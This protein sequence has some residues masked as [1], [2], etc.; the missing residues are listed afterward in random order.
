MIHLL[1]YALLFLFGC[2][3]SG[4]YA[5]A[6]KAWATVQDEAGTALQMAY[7]EGLQ[8]YTSTNAEGAF[9]L[10]A[11]AQDSLRIS[12]IGFEPLVVAASDC[13]GGILVLRFEVAGLAAAHVLGLKAETVLTRMLAHAEKNHAKGAGYHSG[14]YRLH[15][16]QGQQ[17][18]QLSE[19]LLAVDHDGDDVVSVLRTRAITDDA[20]LGELGFGMSPEVVLQMDKAM[21]PKTYYPFSKK[22]RKHHVYRLDDGLVNVDGRP[23]YKLFFDAVMYPRKGALKGHVLI[24]TASF[25][26]VYLSS[27]FSPRTQH[28]LK[29]SDGATRAALGLMGLNISQ[30]SDVLKVR[31]QRQEGGVW[32]LITAS[33]DSDLDVRYTREGTGFQP[34]FRM[35]YVVTGRERLELEEH[36]LGDKRMIEIMQADASPDFWADYTILFPDVD[37]ASVA[38]ELGRRNTSHNKQ[39]VLEQ[40]LQDWPEDTGARLD[41]TL[42][43]FER[44]GEFYGLALVAKGDSVIR[45]YASPG[46]DPDT[47]VAIGSIAKTYMAMTVLKLADEAFFELDNP[48]DIWLGDEVA[49]DSP[50]RQLTFRQLLTHRSGLDHGLDQPSVLFDFQSA[51][52]RWEQI[53]AVCGSPILPPDS[54]FRYSNGGY[55]LLGY[56]IES[57]SGRSLEFVVSGELLTELEAYC[58]TFPVFRQEDVKV[59]DIDVAYDPAWARGAGG[60]A[61]CTEDLLLWSNEVQNREIVPKHVWELATTA[62]SEYKDWSAFYGMGWM[63]DG[64]AFQTSAEHPIVYHP[65]TEWNAHS[66]LA[67]QPDTGYTVVLISLDGSFARYPMTDVLFTLLNGE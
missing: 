67:I 14:F 25:A 8:N 28:L 22:G 46:L 26:L 56:V 62:V 53:E 65:G 32:R 61:A 12:H 20:K 49:E 31:Y 37:F 34:H 38:E 7:V 19:A 60:M 41:S 40:V 6:I 39:K 11:A 30:S 33:S 36:G 50:L 51:E 23:A 17:T 9:V 2:G 29:F 16:T 63:M 21:Y 35:D 43:W 58:T 18:L 59:S 57:M 10:L 27:D 1:R 45:K 42:A 64:G 52:T 55:M 48:V 54:A 47:V 66:M 44:E 3:A 24:D 15:G 4:T 5:Q 13:T